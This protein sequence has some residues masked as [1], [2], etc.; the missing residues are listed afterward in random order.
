MYS[1]NAE[2]IHEIDNGLYMSDIFTAENLDILSKFGITHIVT[3]TGHIPPK[4]KDKFEYLVV[5]VDDDPSENLKTH[6][7]K[8][9]KFI[10]SARE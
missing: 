6:F 1:F 2:D 4:Y 7:K 8:C 3:V 5:E 9:I 10:D